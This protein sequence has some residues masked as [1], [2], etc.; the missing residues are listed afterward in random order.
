MKKILS[1]LILLNLCFLQIR[2]QK[3]NVNEVP[4]EVIA[5]FDKRFPDALVSS[6]TNMDNEILVRFINKGENAKAL[7]SL[8]GKWLNT[9]TY[10]KNTEIPQEAIRYYE[11]NYKNKGFVISNY[12]FT[13]KVDGKSYYQLDLTSSA[14]KN[15]ITELYFGIDGKFMGTNVIDIKEPLVNKTGIKDV[16]AYKTVHLETIPEKIIT[17]IKLNYKN[18]NIKQVASITE[19]KNSGG[20][21][22]VLRAPGKTKS[23]ELYYDKFNT[24]I[25]KIEPEEAVIKDVTNTQI[26]KFDLKLYK[27]PQPIKTKELPTP[28]MN[29]IKTNYNGYD[30]SSCAQ[31][32]EEGLQDAYEVKIKKRGDKNKI[33]L[34]FDMYGNLLL[35]IEPIDNV[36]EEN[37][38]FD[39]NVE[40]N[41][42]TLQPN[43]EISAKELPSP[44]SNF[45]R[46]NYKEYFIKKVMY[47]D[48]QEMKN[49]YYVQLKKQAENP[50]DLYFDYMGNLIS[51]N[52]PKWKEKQ[53][54]SENLKEQEKN[55]ITQRDIPEIVQKNFM[56]KNPKATN[57]EWEKEND[58]FLAR[59]LLNGQKA[60][61]CYTPEGNWVYTALSFDKNRLSNPIKT[62]IQKNYSGYKIEYAM[63]IQRADKQ[64]YFSVVLLRKIKGQKEFVGLKFNNSGKFLDNDENVDPDT[65]EQ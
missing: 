34:Y 56:K 64:N 6:W 7:F 38:T 58:N 25:E 47:I 30:I 61:T 52:D 35:K 50:I 39:E 29:Y 16:Q 19:G 49:S 2:A 60:K 20:F 63:Q 12:G 11:T 37:V 45:I 28:V 40:Q 48:N 1:L 3:I 54:E 42:T 57:I 51:N 15:K 17:E 4:D 10:V 59:F 5:N 44:A 36:F 32:V 9:Y 65:G 24:L 21:Y 26:K 22:I 23:I 31:L 43:T 55:K 46:K 33:H 13:Q 27:N 53:Q 62:Y 41:V 14:E 18:Y 8:E